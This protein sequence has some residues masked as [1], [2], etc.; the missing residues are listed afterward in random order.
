VAAARIDADAVREAVEHDLEVPVGDR[1]VDD[2][3]EE[4]RITIQIGA[5][6]KL[7]EKVVLEELRRGLKCVRKRNVSR[8][9]SGDHL[10]MPARNREVAERETI[11]IRL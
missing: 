8:P 5:R 3:V 4:G 11:R 2:A 1:A 10:R 6:R 7:P 9:A